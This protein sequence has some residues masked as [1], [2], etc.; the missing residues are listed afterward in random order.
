VKFHA[1]YSALFLKSPNRLLAN[2][3]SFES[4][5]PNIWVKEVPYG[6]RKGRKTVKR[7]SIAL[8]ALA[9][10][11]AI[12]PAALADTY[13]FTISSSG[14][15]GSGVITV[16]QQG[17]TDVYEVTGIT[18]TFSDAT[19]GLTNAAIT[20]LITASYDSNNPTFYPGTGTASDNYPAVDDLF[21]PNGDAPGV[22]FDGF[23]FP[24]IG[25]LDAWGIL[26]SVGGDWVNIMGNGGGDNGYEIAAWPSDMTSILEGSTAGSTPV[27]FDATV[28]PEPPSLLFMG[29]GLLGLAVV[30][31]RKNK[32]SSLVLH[33]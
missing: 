19:L 10:A 29:T 30:L 3:R 21:Y 23:T 33:S 17:S 27:S 8:L 31:F 22:S 28:T 18:G 25:Q 13:D 7:F 5:P 20:A 14:D 2:L 6:F 24:A 11:L 9:T 12:T 1:E 16:A 32:P 26:F 15:N 4:P